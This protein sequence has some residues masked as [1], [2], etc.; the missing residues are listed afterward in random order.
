MARLT[1]DAAPSKK[2]KNG[3]TDQQPPKPA[4]LTGVVEAVILEDPDDWEQLVQAGCSFWRNVHTREIRQVCIHSSRKFM[5]CL[6]LCVSH[7][8][9]RRRSLRCVDRTTRTRVIPDI[10]LALAPLC[11]IRPSTPSCDH[12]WLPMDLRSLMQLTRVAHNI[13]TL[14]EM[15]PNRHHRPVCYRPCKAMYLQTTVKKNGISFL[16]PPPLQGACARD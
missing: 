11:S 16:P 12:G 14:Y 13:H 2:K 7:S 4:S 9:A 10:Q 1:K 8:I 15:R 6:I 5:L 3:V